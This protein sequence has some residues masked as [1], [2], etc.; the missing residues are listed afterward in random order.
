MNA[1]ELAGFLKSLQES[2]A[3]IRAVAYKSVGTTDIK[4]ALERMGVRLGDEPNTMTTRVSIDMM[5]DL[6]L[7][8]PNDRGIRPFDRFLSGPALRLPG[9]E[10]DIARR[11][12]RSCFSIFRYAEKAEPM[13]SQMEDI[14]DDDRRIW[15]VTEDDLEP[16]PSQSFFAMRVI[17]AGPCYALLS[18]VITV[19]DRIAAVFKRAHV[20]GR[21]PYRRSLAATIYGITYLRGQPPVSVI[22]WRFV[23][24]LGAE[25]RP[26]GT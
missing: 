15:L 23:D 14:L 1:E 4:R 24:E 11:M 8:E 7:F 25:L 5:S 13:G 12:G 10:L 3:N 16:D 22:G 17:D 6:T 18:R 21:R 20:T 2:M 9:H 26:S 19:P